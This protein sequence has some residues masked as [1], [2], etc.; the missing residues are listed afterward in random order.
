MPAPLGAQAWDLSA[1]GASVPIGPISRDAG[2]RSRARRRCRFVVVPAC[3]RARGGPQVGCFGSRVQG[4]IAGL[5]VGG[6]DARSG[7]A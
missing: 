7:D 1:F 3:G 6:P 5:C 4:R 2:G